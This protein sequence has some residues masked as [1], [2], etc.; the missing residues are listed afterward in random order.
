MSSIKIDNFIQAFHD[1][2]I[3]L[4][5][6]LSIKSDYAAM[7]INKTIKANHGNGAVDPN[8]P[9]SWRYYMNLAG[10]YHPLDKPMYIMSL[11]TQKEILFSPENLY[12]HTATR[13]AYQLGSRYHHKLL[14]EFPDQEALIHGILYPADKA[15]A[16]EAR[17]GSILAYSPDL[18]E[19]HERT[20]IIELE[21]YIKRVFARW[22][23]GAYAITDPY[24]PAMFFS[25]LAGLCVT[26]VIRLRK[27]RRKTEEV[28]SFYLKEYL[29]SHNGLDRYFPYLTRDQQLFL[30]RN[31][32]YI[33]R[34]AGQSEI[35]DVLVKEILDVRQIPLTDY[36]VRQLQEEDA[37]GYPKVVARRISLTKTQTVGL[38]PYL[39][40]DLFFMRERTTA[41]G[42]P[43][44]FEVSEAEIR[45]TLATTD[46]SAL[47]TKDL[48]SSMVDLT[49]SVPD[50]LED[51]FMRQWIY[52]TQ[53]GLYN[54][55]VNFQDPITTEERSL[56]SR[57]AITYLTYLTF[58]RNGIHFERLPPVRNVK[59]RKHPRPAV[60][61]LHALIPHDF[62][63]NWMRELAYD[64]VGAQPTLVESFSVTM[65]HE[66]TYKI[67]EESL[68]HFFL[69]AQ[70]GDPM[71]RGILE[72]M[73]SHLFS[74]AYWDFQP[75]ED[76]ENWR[77][78]NNLPAY[79]YTK[80]EADIIIKEIFTRATGFMIDETKQLR[81]IQ[82][83]LI[84]LFIDLS[85]YSIQ[86]MREINDADLYLVGM[87]DLRVGDI[88]G[89]GEDNLVVRDGVRALG[90]VS[91]G[92]DEI[93]LDMDRS[94]DDLS[95]EKPVEE[96]QVV[97]CSA[98]A[99]AVSM[100]DTT[101]LV[102]MNTRADSF[103]LSTST[104]DP[105]DG[106]IR[107]DDPNRVFNIDF[108][109]AFKLAKFL[110]ENQ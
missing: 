71:Q 86:I 44:Y 99:D 107:V 52:M 3:A 10:E 78:R 81:Y 46:S 63:Y 13:E 23:V 36:S 16:I 64:L 105:L 84:D 34:N 55:V 87:P 75:E 1:L 76:I 82:K 53:M 21:A 33:Q 67:Y 30:Y 57:D 47:Q 83:A 54:V 45:H 110:G 37:N 62:R 5:K 51:V 40:L 4:I 109:R 80:D 15:Y 103:S 60:E 69:M 100:D 95:I 9:S 101:N 104:I 43:R 74:A 49:N 12:R 68:R 88:R 98:I 35:F 59:F 94:W 72:Q 85:S 7:A 89:E 24:Y 108:D 39:D 77:I 32:K 102:F 58:K 92:T 56:L 14:K 17:E 65:F 11:D 26:E 31:I 50:R 66:T 29:A 90:V 38:D 18:V 22:Y 91:Y 48:E 6:T 42:N 2:N 79:T 41:V 8:N 96:A 25:G 27:E 20:L 19:D 93:Q 28:H 61:E 70:T 97:Y 106:T 73:C